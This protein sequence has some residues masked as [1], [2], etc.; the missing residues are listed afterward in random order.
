MDSSTDWVAVAA[1]V[2]AVAALAFTVFSWRRVYLHSGD[3]IVAT[4]RTYAYNARPNG[5]RLRLPLV[6]FNDGAVAILVT[7]LRIVVDDAHPQTWITTRPTLLPGGGADAHEF[8]T[9][10]A[11]HG[12]DTREEIIEFGDD[13]GAWRP[14]SNASYTVRVEAQ[15]GSDDSWRQL[16]SFTWWGPI[17]PTVSTI[18]LRNAQDPT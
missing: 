13:D 10:F 14:A 11:V 4:P 9:P 2:V 1:V 3:L 18:V 7:N 16:G 15:V 6:F 5:F 17:D 12:R 8:A